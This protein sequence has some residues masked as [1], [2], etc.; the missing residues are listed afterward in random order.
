[1]PESAKKTSFLSLS[2]PVLYE[3]G[4]STRTKCAVF[5]TTCGVLYRSVSHDRDYKPENECTVL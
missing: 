3:Y 4:Y 1:M 5:N 2:F